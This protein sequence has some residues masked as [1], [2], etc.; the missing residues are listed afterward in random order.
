MSVVDQ[1]VPDGIGQ[2]GVADGGMPMLNGKLAGHDG[3]AGPVA[4]IEH[5]QQVAPVGIVEHGQSPIVNHERVYSGQ[6]D[7]QLAIASVGAVDAKFIE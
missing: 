7:E 6:L 1:P 2:G 4:V 5:L 3:Q